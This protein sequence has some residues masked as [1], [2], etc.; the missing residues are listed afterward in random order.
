M[1]AGTRHAVAGGHVHDL[2]HDPRG[3]ATL[4]W[5]RT[6]ERSARRPSSLQ[7]NVDTVAGGLTLSPGTTSS[8]RGAPPGRLMNATRPPLW[9]SPTLPRARISSVNPDVVTQRGTVVARGFS[10]SMLVMRSRAEPVGATDS[11]VTRSPRFR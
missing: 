10:A 6:T 3:T 7:P 1:R 9:F 5:A 11:P 4:P 2:R 8:Q